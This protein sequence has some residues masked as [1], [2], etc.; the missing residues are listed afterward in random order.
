MK[1]I[2]ICYSCPLINGVTNTIEKSE[3]KFDTKK[4]AYNDMRNAALGRMQFNSSSVNFKDGNSNKFEINFVDD[5]IIEKFNALCYN[6]SIKECDTFEVEFW[7]Y[8]DELISILDQEDYKTICLGLWV[9]DVMDDRTKWTEYFSKYFSETDI[10]K[11]P[12]SLDIMSLDN[13]IISFPDDCL[14]FETK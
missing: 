11:L 3:K 1:Y 6:Y 9:T 7:N 8:W 4:D 5:K 13:E 2:W 14:W 12:I 10:A